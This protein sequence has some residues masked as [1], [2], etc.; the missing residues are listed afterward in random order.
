M[1]YENIYN[2]LVTRGK[3]R[4]LEGYKESHHIVPRCLGGNDD[5]SNLVDLTP[6]GSAMLLLLCFIQFGTISLTILSYSRT[7]K[8]LMKPV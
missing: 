5:S 6:E 3:N 8:E 7:I 1:N 2:S 4:V